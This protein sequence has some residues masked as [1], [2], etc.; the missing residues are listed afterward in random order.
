MTIK[1]HQYLKFYLG[2]QKRN[3]EELFADVDFKE[4]EDSGGEM[5]LLQ[6]L[7]FR[8]NKNFS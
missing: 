2:S 6:E 3:A 7:L 4:S 1:S 8:G 5:L